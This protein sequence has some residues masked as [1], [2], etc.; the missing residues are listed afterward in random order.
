MGK[1][2]STSL[3][4]LQ[5]DMLIWQGIENDGEE[6]AGDSKCFNDVSYAGKGINF[7]LG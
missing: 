1:S 2:V 6:V 3:D 5:E 7:W 4:L